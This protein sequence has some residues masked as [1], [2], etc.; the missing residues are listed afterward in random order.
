MDETHIHA[1]DILGTP[2]KSDWDLPVCFLPITI[3]LILDLRHY[4][5]RG[6]LLS[7]LVTLLRPIRKEEEQHPKTQGDAL[8]KTPFLFICISSWKMASYFRL[9]DFPKI[10]ASSR[11]H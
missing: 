9:K 4:N 5:V 6:L 10:N 1:R 7:G 11:L 2:A 8:P 3:N